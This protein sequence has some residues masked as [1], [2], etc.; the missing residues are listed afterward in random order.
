MYEQMVETNNCHNADNLH[1]S[2]V[3][4][5]GKQNGAGMGRRIRSGGRTNRILDI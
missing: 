3:C 5:A 1:G 2:R 4:L